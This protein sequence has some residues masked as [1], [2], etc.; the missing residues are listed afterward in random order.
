MSDASGETSGEPQPLILDASIAIAILRG[1]PHAAEWLD[2]IKRQVAS[3]GK[4]QVPSLFWL[5]VVNVL[6]RRY[7]LQPSDVL[8][9]IVE[10]E[11]TGVETVELDRPMLLLVLDAVARH[12][13]TAYNAAYLAVAVATDGALMTADARLAAATADE[14]GRAVR[15]SPASYRSTT[16]IDWPGAASYLRDLRARLEAP[17]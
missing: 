14:G 1:E 13:L 3:N 4:L 9:A 17:T 7:R 2:R 8:E 10:L 5:E 6:L 15:E 16:W 12:D 11:A